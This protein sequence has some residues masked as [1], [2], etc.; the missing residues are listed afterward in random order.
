MDMGRFVRKSY[1]FKG[2][3]QWRRKAV[4]ALNSVAPPHASEN[5]EVLRLQIATSKLDADTL[6]HL[7]KS[8]CL[9]V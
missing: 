4:K 9:N 6:G 8:G 5:G 2:S 7:S 3:V 1:F